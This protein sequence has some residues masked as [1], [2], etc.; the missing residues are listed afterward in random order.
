MTE[1][2]DEFLEKLASSSPTPGG[3]SVSALSGAMGAALSSMVCNLTTGKKGYEDVEADLQQM[4]SQTEQLRTELTQL[5]QEDAQAFDGVMASFRLPKDTEKQKQKR[6]QAIQESLKHAAEVPMQV[7]RKCFQVI[8]LSKTAAEKGNKNSVSDAGVSALVA[9]AGLQGALLN[10]K[11]NLSSI[12]D[13]EFNQ[14]LSQEASE[15]EQKAE[16]LTK[17]TLSIVESKM[18]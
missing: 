14:K 10:V 3:G 4:L 13:E 12:K 17:E 1:N 9:K 8:E 11:I 7:A 2:V 15:L 18:A 5:V 16:T 6:R